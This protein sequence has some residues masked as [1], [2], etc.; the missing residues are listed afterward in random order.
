M[1]AGHIPRTDGRRASDAELRTMV[2]ELRRALQSR[3]V[4]E[5]AKGIL[6]E[7]FA[8]S[9][10]QAFELLRYTA[11]SRRAEIHVLAK[12]VVSNHDIT[13][14]EIV[15]ALAK[16]TQWQPNGRIHQP[17]STTVTGGTT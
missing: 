14:A 3:I 15:A 2:E 6:A 12:Q 10:D 17:E 16:Q 13:P 5:Q 9:L 4:I 7:R 1:N 11:R 8:L